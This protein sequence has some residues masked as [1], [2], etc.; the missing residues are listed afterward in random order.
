MALNVAEAE[1]APEGLVWAG[2]AVTSALGRMQ[3]TVRFDNVST[4]NIR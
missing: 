2:L 4:R 1:W 3:T